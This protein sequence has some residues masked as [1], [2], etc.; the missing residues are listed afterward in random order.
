MNFV[1]LEVVGFSLYDVMYVQLLSILFSEGR[2]FKEIVGWEHIRPIFPIN[3]ICLCRPVF[4]TIFWLF[5][6]H[7]TYI[8]SEKQRCQEFGD[9]HSVSIFFP[10]KSLQ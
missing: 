5:I 9:F 7:W 8:L 6:S 3:R 10:G 1:V 4:C 2:R